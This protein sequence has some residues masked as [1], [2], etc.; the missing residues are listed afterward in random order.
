MENQFPEFKVERREVCKGSVVNKHAKDTFP[1]SEHKSRGILDLLLS[2]VCGPMSLASLA[3][4]LYDVIFIN[5]SY[6]KN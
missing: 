2:E 6:E 4:N 5:D 3:G 1:S